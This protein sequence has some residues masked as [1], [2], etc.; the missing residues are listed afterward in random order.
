[1]AYII[2]YDYLRLI[3]AGNLQQLITSNPGVL[4]GIE[5]SAQA[6]AISYLKQKYETA[7][8]F[9]ETMLWTR[10]K[11]YNAFD[12]VY[13]DAPGYIA[14]NTYYAEDLTTW[15]GK[16]YECSNTTTGVFDP[17]LWVLLGTQG[18]MYYAAYPHPLFDVYNLYKE[19]DQVYWNGHIYTAR[20]DSIVVTDSIQYRTYKNIPLPN[21]FPD[22]PNSGST[23]WED[24]G[25]YSV[26]YDTDIT[27]TDYWTKGDNRDQQMVLYMI[28]IALYHVHSRIAP[29]NIPQLRYDRYTNAIAWLKMCAEGNVTPNLPKIQPKE[30]HRI[31]Y[32]GNIRN[33][34]TY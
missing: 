16:V 6:E 15:N 28:D 17:A 22:A 2:S 13:L 25:A 4:S 14:A 1:M 31:R 7:D 19:G 32:G 10:N 24:N 29:N 21:V 34:N 27:D 30:G 12:R 5:L 18:D 9:T 3:Q 23:Y 8:E 11:V 26:P 33:I 20:R